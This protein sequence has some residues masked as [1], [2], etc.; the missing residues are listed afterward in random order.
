ML[1]KVSKMALVR[2]RWPSTAI[3]SLG[4]SMS[5]ASMDRRRRSL[6]HVRFEADVTRHGQSLLPLR[7]PRRVVSILNQSYGADASSSTSPDRSLRGPYAYAAPA[8]TQTAI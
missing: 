1:R 3:V 7:G 6:L 4:R 5:G 8:L 2:T